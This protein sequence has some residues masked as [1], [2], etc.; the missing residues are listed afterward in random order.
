M[1]QTRGPRHQVD[2]D[3]L[4]AR[5]V[6]DPVVWSLGEPRVVEQEGLGVAELVG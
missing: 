3:R 4:E 5:L 2:M 1:E 6:K